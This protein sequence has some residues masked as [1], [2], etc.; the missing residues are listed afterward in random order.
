MEDNWNAK[1]YHGAKA[2]GHESLLGIRCLGLGPVMKI[3]LERKR[4][5]CETFHIHKK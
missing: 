5:I 2:A 3:G 1:M 4:K